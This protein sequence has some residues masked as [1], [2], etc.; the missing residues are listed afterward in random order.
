MR[1]SQIGKY[2][3]EIKKNAI[4]RIYTNYYANHP[5]GV[6]YDVIRESHAIV[7]SYWDSS[8]RRT[9]F[10]GSDLNQLCKM[11]M[12]QEEGSI[13]DY[14]G[15][16]DDTFLETLK[17]SGFYKFS[18]FLRLSNRNLTHIFDPISNPYGEY[19]S[20]FLESK[21][22]EK[23][24]QGDLEE[25]YNLLLRTFDNRTSHFQ[26]KEEL[27][28]IIKQGHVLI[29]KKKERIVSFIIFYFQ[30]KKFYTAH[31]LNG[32]ENH[33]A[34]CMYAQ[35]AQMAIESGCTYAYS[36]VE[37][38]NKVSLRSNQL[39]QSFPDGMTDTIFVKGELAL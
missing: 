3:S 26:S 29:H 37:E 16:C 25:L 1:I 39:K 36:W 15:K 33:I 20:R 19:M 35:A 38:N 24:C 7:F 22:I 18:R 21:E 2:I 4:S 14:I 30:G 10:Y 17:Q 11:L 34:L 5:E 6:G 23:A 27:A 9:F 8:V 28:E 12:N 31:I 13:I 32:A